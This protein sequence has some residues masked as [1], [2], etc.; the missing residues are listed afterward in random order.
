MKRKILLTIIYVLTFFIIFISNVYTKTI[1]AENCSQSEVEKAI[2]LASFG[3]TVVVPSGNCIWSKAIKIPTGVTFKGAGVGN[4]IVSG[5]S[6]Y[7]IYMG[8][9]SRVTGFEFG[10]DFDIQAQGVDNWRI[11]HNKFQQNG[12][13]N[14]CI[15]IGSKCVADKKH[16]TGLID[17]N[18]IMNGRIGIFGCS[19][20]GMSDE[21]WYTGWRDYSYPGEKIY[22]EDNII[23]QTSVTGVVDGNYSGRY[24]LR[25]NTIS[26]GYIE[27]HGARNS[28]GLQSWEIYRNKIEN[29]NICPHAANIRGGTGVIFDNDCSGNANQCEWAFSTERCSTS[30]SYSG[31]CDGKS[32]WDTS[33]HPATGSGYLCR[34]SFAGKDSRLGSGLQQNPPNSQES[35]PAYMWGNTENTWSPWNAFLSQSCIGKFVENRDFYMDASY[36][37]NYG[38]GGVKIG[39]LASRPANCTPYEAYWATDQ[40]NWNKKP[41]GAQGVLY[42][43]T[44]PNTWTLYYTPYTYPHP[45]REASGDSTPPPPGAMPTPPKG[46]RIFK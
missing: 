4:T 40:G 19:D 32:A 14:G 13:Q 7:G 34:D 43:C 15:G 30:Y 12:S 21:L 11:D 46:L 2:N 35:H 45:L 17:N 44:A 6:G 18:V 26:E 27:A 8:S 41:G 23:T 36:H 20:D 28:R 25:F 9:N 16:V 10:F 31:L 1:D 22:I 33:P 3:D 39:T 29:L 5:I 42:K 38:N 24:V 37:N